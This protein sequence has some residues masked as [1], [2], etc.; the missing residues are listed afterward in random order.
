MFM[1][2]Y[3]LQND[4]PGLKSYYL[5]DRYK[6]DR[7]DSDM[8]QVMESHSDSYNTLHGEANSVQ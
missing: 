5:P 6:I 8:T 3:I 7:G 1:V 2:A 4:P